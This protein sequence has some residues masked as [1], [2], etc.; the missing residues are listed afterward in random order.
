MTQRRAVVGIAFNESVTRVLLVEKQRP[1][2][3]AGLFNGVGGKVEEGESPV[4]AVSREFFEQAGLDITEAAWT[5][6]IT[7]RGPDFEITFYQIFLPD[8][9]FD[10]AKTATDEEVTPVPLS[11]IPKVRTIFNLQYIVPMMM[12]PQLKWPIVIS[13]K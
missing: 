3:Q 1:K 7:Y 2:W 13:K 9:M 8:K 4:G 12:D 6:C 10:S 11:E 5:H